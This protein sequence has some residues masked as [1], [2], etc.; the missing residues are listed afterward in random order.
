M[1]DYTERI[2]AEFEAIEKT[3]SSFPS[4]NLS[5]LSPLELAGA[6][7]LLHNFYNGIENVLK[8]VF[9]KRN[10][11]IRDGQSWHKDLIDD[12]VSGNLISES[13]ANELKR[14]LAFRHFFS[15]GYALD[16]ISDRLEPL[17]RDA[18]QIFTNFKTDIER[19]ITSP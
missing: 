3:L 10:L 7:A 16:L 6:A 5:A 13:L 17:V 2:D 11:K 15:H 1:V 9:Q 19:I 18:R 4:S 8:Q 12:A 14:Y